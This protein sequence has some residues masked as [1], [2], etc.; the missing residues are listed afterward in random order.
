MKRAGPYGPALLIDGAA[1]LYVLNGRV[2]DATRCNA[3]TVQLDAAGVWAP[4]LLGELSAHGSRRK[5]WIV[6]IHIVVLRVL[7]NCLDQIAIRA[8]TSNR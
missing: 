7:T 1:I 6:N 2:L 3:H 4:Q 5:L 8:D